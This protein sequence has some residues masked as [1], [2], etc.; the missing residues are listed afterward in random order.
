MYFLNNYREKAYE[1]S[2]ESFAKAM[3]DSVASQFYER[4]GDVQAFSVNPILKTGE[5]EEIVDLLNT[6]SKLYGIY[7]LILFVDTTGNLKAVNNRDPEGNLI[8]VDKL[9]ERNFKDTIWFQSAIKNLS[10]E[11]KSN[12]LTGTFVEQPSFDEFVSLAYREQKVNMGFTAPVK[13]KDGSIIGIITNRASS[14]WYENAMKSQLENIVKI[15]YNSSEILLMNNSGLLISE[16]TNQKEFATSHPMNLFQTNLI[17]M[18]I[19][20]AKL[21]SYREIGSVRQ[22][23]DSDGKTRLY[24]YNKISNKNFLNSLS[25]SVLI[26]A[27]L[28][29]VFAEINQSK[30][31]FYF[32]FFIVVLFSSVFSILYFDRIVRF[33]SNTSEILFSGS[34]SVSVA[35]TQLNQASQDLSSSLTEQS[36]ALQTTSSAADQ[37]SAM[38]K[39]SAELAEQAEKTMQSS[40]DEAEIGDTMINKMK[41]AINDIYKNNELISNE[42]NINSDKI[43][44]IVKVIEE[45]GSKLHIINE[46]VF[47]TKILSFNASV[48]AARAGDHGRGF[49]VVAEEVGNLAQTSGNAAKE[50]N[51]LLENSLKTVQSIARESKEKI[52]V[53][54]KSADMS[55]KEGATIANKCID[56]LKNIVNSSSSA[57]E[58]MKNI[59]QA[60]QESATGVQE[61][62]KSLHQ[63]DQA[64]KT[65]ENAANSCSKSSKSLLDEVSSINNAAAGLNSIVTGYVTTLSF[66]WRDDY[67]LG[68]SEMDDEHKILVHKIN[69]LAEALGKQDKNV[70]NV[71]QNLVSYTIEHFTHEESYLEHLRYP[72]INT[73]KNIH[74]NL[75]QKLKGF[76]VDVEKGKVDSTELTSFL[77]NWLLGHILGV[78]MKYARF[79][80]GERSKSLTH[81]E[82]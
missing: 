81:I 79:S 35:S 11:D 2:F 71:F 60:S 50:I 30:I 38:V 36:Y 28:D 40:K 26:S 23:D 27:D 20:A 33:L 53:I 42:M 56:I 66:E 29:E 67:L 37:I 55:V 13:N 68:V 49:A 9:Y 21:S 43:F 32:I 74:K 5:R 22:Y 65:I 34:R 57:N 44:S 62:A 52:S 17:E 63:V 10:S 19:E 12:G 45:V 41:E 48:E 58:M 69:D 75:I 77:N 54:I 76:E 6:M 3:S 78:D 70:L 24:S 64:T 46:I 16:I 15:G 47:Q 82:N 72:A 59:S 7:E 73:H 25:W 51:L 80:R 18:N 1:K 61:I 4:Y 8:Q 14:N 31:N 39:R